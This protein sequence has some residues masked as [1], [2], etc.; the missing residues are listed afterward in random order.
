MKGKTGW[1]GVILGVSAASTQPFVLLSTVN[2]DSILWKDRELSDK[3]I[4]FIHRSMNSQNQFILIFCFWLYRVMG[5]ELRLKAINLE[6]IVMQIRTIQEWPS[7]PNF[8]FI[9]I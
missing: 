5:S 9:W 3:K 2:K 7:G 1:Q 8:L 4:L 6:V